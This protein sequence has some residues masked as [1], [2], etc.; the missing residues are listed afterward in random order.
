MI[1]YLTVI[2]FLKRAWLPLTCILLIV[3]SGI[4]LYNKGKQSCEAK[5]NRVIVE[6]QIQ[7]E[8]DVE[9]LFRKG[10]ELKDRVSRS[11]SDKEASCILSSNPFD[12]ECFK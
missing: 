12:K 3:S 2:A 8:E 7:H 5:M 10:S 11:L 9:L 1:G 4:Y 6:Y